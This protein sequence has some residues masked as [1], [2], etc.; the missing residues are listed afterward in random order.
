MCP[1]QADS[2]DGSIRCKVEKKLSTKDAD[3]AAQFKA[4]SKAI[5]EG[6]KGVEISV[7]S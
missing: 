3:K 5:L 2:V 4:K 7:A 6:V 1:L